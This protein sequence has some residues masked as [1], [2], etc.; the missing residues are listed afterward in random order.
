MI[1]IM[2]KFPSFLK[3]EDYFNFFDIHITKITLNYIDLV[4]KRLKIEEIL[5]LEFFAIQ[6]FL[7]RNHDNYL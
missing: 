1:S 6:L 3:S 7:K 4:S 2:N 5:Q